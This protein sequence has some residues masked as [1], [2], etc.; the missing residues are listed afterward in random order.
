LTVSQAK[1]FDNQVYSYATYEGIQ[2]G[3]G[4]LHEKWHH[5]IYNAKPTDENQLEDSKGSVGF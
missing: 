5:K 1:S 4:H 2:E 3:K